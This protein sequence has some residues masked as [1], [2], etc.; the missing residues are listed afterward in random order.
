MR[1]AGAQ[2]RWTGGARRGRRGSESDVA[3]LKIISELKA[4]LQ[5]RIWH[6]KASHTSLDIESCARWRA[7]R[8][9]PMSV[10]N[11]GAD[12]AARRLAARTVEKII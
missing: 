1:E 4:R 8:V 10:H 11:G 2:G 3:G 5:F 7:V 12:D 6:G 9:R